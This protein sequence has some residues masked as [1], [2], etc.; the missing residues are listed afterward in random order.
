[1]Y[2]LH[3][4]IRGKLIKPD[5]LDNVKVTSALSVFGPA[6]REETESPGNDNL[7]QN[8]LQGYLPKS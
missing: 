8:N 6:A 1:M 2:I 4:T 5:H 7:N 3:V